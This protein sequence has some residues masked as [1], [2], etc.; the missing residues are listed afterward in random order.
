ML[1]ESA[2]GKT[3]KKYSLDCVFQEPALDSVLQESA[4]GETYKESSLGGVF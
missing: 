2:L 1:Q 4:L 3:H